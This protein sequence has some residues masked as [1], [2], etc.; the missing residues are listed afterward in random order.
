M[1][2][3]VYLSSSHNLYI[4]LARKEYNMYIKTV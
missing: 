2:Q 3:V 1:I 4:Y